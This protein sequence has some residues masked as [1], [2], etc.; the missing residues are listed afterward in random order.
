MMSNDWRNSFLDSLIVRITD[1]HV[2]DLYKIKVAMSDAREHLRSKMAE[3][4]HW[5]AAFVS[6][7]PRVRT[8][9]P[10]A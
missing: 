6:N 1:K 9:A 8:N 2:E 10:S 4:V 5:A 7:E 3:L